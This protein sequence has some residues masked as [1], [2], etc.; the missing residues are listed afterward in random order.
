VRKAIA[1]AESENYW[2]VV[3]D[4]SSIWIGQGKD[5]KRIA[6][7]P[8]GLNAHEEEMKKYKDALQKMAQEKQELKGQLANVKGTL[9]LR[10]KEAE[11]HYLEMSHIREVEIPDLEMKNAELQCALKKLPE[12][13]NVTGDE[14]N[15]TIF[16]ILKEN[17]ITVRNEIINDNKLTNEEKKRSLD[18]LNRACKVLK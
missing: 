13:V 11:D 7:I 9:K 3:C 16:Q 18:Y 1:I 12:T 14:M 17:Y 8:Q 5:W 4:D 15:L 10:D 2:S 6:G